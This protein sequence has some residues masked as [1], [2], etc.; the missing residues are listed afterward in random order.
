MC[1]GKRYKESVLRIKHMGFSISD[2][3]DLDIREIK[4]IFKNDSDIY[5]AL[6]MLCKVG[7]SYI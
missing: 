2:L 3:L 7:P 4:E 6:D 5:Q 1:K